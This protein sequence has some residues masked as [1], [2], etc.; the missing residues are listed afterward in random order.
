MTSFGHPLRS[1]GRVAFAR[2][3]S[4]LLYGILAAVVASFA[5]VILSTVTPNEL[6]QKLDNP[7]TSLQTGIPIVISLGALYWLH[8]FSGFRFRH[9]KASLGYP[10]FVLAVIIGLIL[11][12]IFGDSSTWFTLAKTPPVFSGLVAYF[13]VLALV[14]G[15]RWLFDHYSRSDAA[16]NQRMS[17]PG[18]SEPATM[19]CAQIF[20]WSQREVPILSEAE[21]I[22]GYANF[23]FR[24]ER[25][26]GFLT[27][28]SDSTVAIV[29]A[30]GAGKTSLVNLVRKLADDR[31]TSGLWFVQVSCWGFN[32]AAAAQKLIL[33]QMISEISKRIDCLA[34]RTLPQAYVKALA[35]T[36]KHFEAF[37]SLFES[38]GPDDQIRRVSPI[39]EAVNARLVIVIE[40]T[41]RNGSDFDIG[42]IEALLQRFRN[43]PG[44][45]FVVTAGPDSKIDFTR[46]C[47]HLEVLPELD[48]ATVLSFLD[49]VLKE[50]LK[51]FPEDVD[52]VNRT[53]GLVDSA[54]MKIFEYTSLARNTWEWQMTRLISTPRKLKATVRRFWN[55][56][57]K[58]HG[59]VDVFE[60]LISSCLRTCT[61]AVFGFLARRH[62]DFRGTE[63]TRGDGVGVNA[64]LEGLKREW[65]QLGPDIDLYP[66]SRL[67]EALY[68]PC[69]VMF[70]KFEQVGVQ[71]MQPFRSLERPIYRDRIFNEALSPK[72]GT[73][74]PV[75]RAIVKAK[76]G[77]SGRLEL[78]SCWTRTRVFVT[79]S[80]SLPLMRNW[81]NNCGTSLYS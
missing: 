81:E 28:E 72:G 36:S 10:S 65:A 55:A 54:T 30:F 4:I 66:A 25:L 78:A 34:I 68:P 9:L 31:N 74:Q 40:D 21:D 7:S 43:T 51:A 32:D 71:S 53:K 58:L 1:S 44:L 64:T 15:V 39:L 48:G 46:L 49:T 17:Q 79:C 29:G 11:A 57:Q 50:A 22:F 24:A 13:L 80:T 3:R 14:G 67:L 52:L 76:Q 77:E 19:T 23:C 5:T 59:E 75:L 37:L 42:C 20:E 73:D 38:G 8:W 69:H 60:L 61:P 56:W 45:S 12:G 26:L 62:Q 70:G 47:E 35:S 41:D 33:G 16:S 18:P 27:A 2:W 6:Q 63:W